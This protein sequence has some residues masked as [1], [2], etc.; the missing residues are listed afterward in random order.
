MLKSQQQHN[1]HIFVFHPG[2]DQPDA[3]NKFN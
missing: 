2:K 1:Q 3:N